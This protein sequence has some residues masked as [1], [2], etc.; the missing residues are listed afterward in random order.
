MGLENSLKAE[1]DTYIKDNAKNFFYDYIKAEVSDDFSNIH[2]NSQ[3]LWFYLT[4]SGYI[5]R[6]WLEKRIV[7]EKDFIKDVLEKYPEPTNAIGKKH[8]EVVDVLLKDIYKILINQVDVY[9]DNYPDISRYI[10]QYEADIQT[11]HAIERYNNPVNW[12]AADPKEYKSFS[13]KNPD[14]FSDLLLFE[15]LGKKLNEHYQKRNKI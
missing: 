5:G 6:S 1:I 13:D 4:L 3:N 9:T 14:F 8:R 11:Y 2:F 15:I 7:E 12:Y 10:E